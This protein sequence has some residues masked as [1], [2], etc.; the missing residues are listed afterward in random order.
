MKA[1]AVNKRFPADPRFLV[2]TADP[3]AEAGGGRL[4]P[5]CSAIKDLDEWPLRTV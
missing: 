3:T 5:V 1:R 4:M 2:E